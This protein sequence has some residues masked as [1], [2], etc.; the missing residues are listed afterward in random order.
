[1]IIYPLI[2]SKQGGNEETQNPDALLNSLTASNLTV[3]D[4]KPKTM[5]ISV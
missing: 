1:M 5:W 2:G 4:S 3:S